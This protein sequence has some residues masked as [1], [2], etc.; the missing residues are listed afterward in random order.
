MDNKVNSIWAKSYKIA[1]RECAMPRAIAIIGIMSLFWW[2]ALHTLLS[3]NFF[4]KVGV[5]S[6]AGPFVT[7]IVYRVI[8]RSTHPFDHIESAYAEP[9]AQVRELARQGRR[10]QATSLYRRETG[11]W[12]GVKEAVV[13][14]EQWQLRPETKLEPPA[15]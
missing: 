7:L 10:L 13:L 12:L 3:V 14:A 9:S 2:G 1:A 6:L 15:A 4:I 11:T 5:L 8:P